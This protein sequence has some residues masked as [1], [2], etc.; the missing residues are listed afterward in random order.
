MSED[1]SQQPA[2]SGQAA[3]GQVK[4]KRHI[5]NY[6]LD[7]GFQLRFTG[8]IVLIST[9]LT[10]SL[11]AFVMSK[12]REASR[13]VEVRAMDPTD[14]VAAELV[15][16]FRRNDQMLMAGLI[17]F[18]V[19]LIVFLLGYGIVLTHKVAGPLY[20]IGTYL[21]RIRDGK[22]YPV[23]ALRKGDQL[24]HFFE[25]FKDTHDALH[26]QT[27]TDITLLDRMIA[28][29]TDPALK[30]ELTTA[31]DAKTESLK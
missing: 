21:D 8:V 31:R 27:E 19:V 17:I 15:E 4:Y 1:S 29:T 7:R 18:A 26:L 20:K 30:T 9:V 28:A 2:A 11:S 24:H 3:G 12:A 6:L 22:L 16:Q 14:T 23:M 25:Q 5:R 10:G 13:V